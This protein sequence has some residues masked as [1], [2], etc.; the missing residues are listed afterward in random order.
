WGGRG[1]WGWMGS[2]PRWL[3]TA[4]DLVSL[5]KRTPVNSGPDVHAL[6]RQA[7]LVDDLEHSNADAVEVVVACRG[8]IDPGELAGVLDVP[9]HVLRRVDGV[10]FNVP[11]FELLRRE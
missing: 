3:A 1:R 7:E 5:L 6:R 8:T 11:L 2:P 4:N 10:H 9:R